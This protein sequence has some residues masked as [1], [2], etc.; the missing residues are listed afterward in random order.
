MLIWFN[1][2][3]FFIESFFIEQ[4]STYCKYL[5]GSIELNIY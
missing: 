3:F 4:I 5:V 2:H 1:N